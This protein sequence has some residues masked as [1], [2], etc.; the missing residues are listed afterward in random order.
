MHVAQLMT[1]LTPPPSG[2]T[3][4][5]YIDKHPADKSGLGYAV[6]YYAATGIETTWD[7]HAS[8]S[9]PGNWRKKVVFTAASQAAVLGSRG[10]QATSDAK[11][12]AARANGA[13]GGRP[14]KAPKIAT[15][16]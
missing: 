7:G 2:A 1:S 10:G 12:E 4:I 3:L 9:L 14:P 15:R 13:K 5:G 16:D 11:A 8:R 6:L